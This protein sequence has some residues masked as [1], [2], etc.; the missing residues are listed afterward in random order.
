MKKTI[1]TIITT[2]LLSGCIISP[3][4]SLH[5]IIENH[6]YEFVNTDDVDMLNVAAIL[7]TF[8]EKTNRENC[9]DWDC[10]DDLKDKYME[11]LE[12][13]PISPNYPVLPN[14]TEIE[15]VD[16]FLEDVLNQLERQKTPI[17]NAGRYLSEASTNLLVEIINYEE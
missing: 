4:Y 2:C 8:V 9:S 5:D 17:H 16:D 7:R 11:T 13:K 10:I 14:H 1:L 3:Q 12:M 6:S 15:Y